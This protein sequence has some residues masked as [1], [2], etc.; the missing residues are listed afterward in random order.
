M[1]F[2]EIELGELRDSNERD[3]DEEL[4][5]E[6]EEVVILRSRGTFPGERVET[7]S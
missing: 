2:G 4:R 7:E 3:A 6:S 5:W 1:A